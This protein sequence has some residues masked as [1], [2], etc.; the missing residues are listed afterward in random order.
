MAIQKNGAA[1]GVSTID[2]TLGFFNDLVARKEKTS[3]PKC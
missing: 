2:V 1:W 3:T